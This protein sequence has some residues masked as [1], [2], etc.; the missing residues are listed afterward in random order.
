MGVKGQV[1]NVVAVPQVFSDRLILPDT[2]LPRGITAEE[3]LGVSRASDGW[4]PVESRVAL[5]TTDVRV[6]FFE[7]GP[8]S[9]GSF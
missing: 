1:W 5:G 8:C 9:L 3:F 4:F 2:L 7:P 6:M